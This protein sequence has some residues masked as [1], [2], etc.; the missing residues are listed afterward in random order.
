[1]TIIR[2]CINVRSSTGLITANKWWIQL[3]IQSDWILQV[4]NKIK[5]QQFIKKISDRARL[6]LK[7]I[8][9]GLLRVQQYYNKK[10]PIYCL[11]LVI[12]QTVLF[13]ST[14][15][16]HRQ[17]KARFTV[18]EPDLRKEQTSR[19]EVKHLSR[20]AGV[21]NL[22]RFLPQEKSSGV[23]AVGI[24]FKVRSASRAAV[25]NTT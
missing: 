2:D 15:N 21:Q 13:R 17:V 24:T 9:I 18:E 12:W 20:D 7:E 10:W 6:I 19:P 25:V 3:I 14:R 5:T 23:L 4:K 11:H 1:M 8:G 22:I 16:T